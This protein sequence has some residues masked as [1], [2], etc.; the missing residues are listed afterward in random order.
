[1]I[2]QLLCGITQLAVLAIIARVILSWFPIGP[3]S[4]FAPIARAIFQVTETM[5]G[6]VRRAVPLAGPLDLSPIIV[7][8]FLQIV[9]QRLILNC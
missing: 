6:P 1:M 5:L 3:S 7:I 2:V 8:L 9:V 4:P